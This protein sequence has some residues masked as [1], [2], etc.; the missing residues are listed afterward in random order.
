MTCA[1]A[2]MDKDATYKLIVLRWPMKFVYDLINDS[3]VLCE[4][5][6]LKVA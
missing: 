4:T 3:K 6:T 1:I 2:L 5:V